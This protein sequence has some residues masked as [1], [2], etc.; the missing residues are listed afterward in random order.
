M[1]HESACTDELQIFGS[2]VVA[3]DDC[4]KFAVAVEV[5]EV[6]AQVAQK[7]WIT[8][9]RGPR[10]RLAADEIEGN[11]QLRMDIMGQREFR[12]IGNGVVDGAVGYAVEQ[13]LSIR[14]GVFHPYQIGQQIARGVQGFRMRAAGGYFQIAAADFRQ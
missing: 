4:R 3:L 14:A 10:E 1:T 13:R 6:A 2:A 9:A 7:S 8:G 12:G 11:A 5:R